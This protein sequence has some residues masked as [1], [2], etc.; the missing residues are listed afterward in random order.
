VDRVKRELADHG[1]IPEEWGG[2]VSMVEVSA[3]QRIGIESLL[4]MILLQAEMAELQANP[5]K[6]ARGHVVEAKLDK[7]RGPVATILVQEGTLKA[8]DVYVCGTHSGRVRNMF[9]HLGQPI[10]EAGPSTPV[11]VLGFPGVPDAGDDF[12]VLSDEKQAKQVAENRQIKR[13]EKELT[14]STKVTLE[15]LYEQIQQGAIKEVNVVL[16]VDVQG[17]LEAISDSLAKLAT[18]DVKV[19]LIHAGTGAITESDIMLATASN[20]IVIGFNV[21][22]DGKVADLAE[23][24]NVDVRYYDVIYQIMSDMKDAMVGML[25]PTYRESVLGRA[26]VRQTFHVPKIG[27]IAGCYVLDGAMLRNARVRVL[28]DQVVVYDGKL[29]SL[30]RFKDDAKEV[31]AGFECGIGVENF[32]DIKVGDILEDYE[33]KEVAPT[34]E[35]VEPGPSE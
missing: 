29:G 16:K 15:K 18:Q 19:Q 21:R 8:G 3:K 24:E 25:E 22:A 33:L 6:P 35:P 28:R 12:V 11:E 30:K 32:N 9:D 27:M 13:R 7:G 5:S 34:L 14:H 31:K 1:L 26:E 20:A 2:D 4:E 17:S 10:E 23:Q